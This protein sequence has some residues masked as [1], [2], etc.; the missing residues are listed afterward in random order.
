MIVNI[1]RIVL[2]ILCTYGI[3]FA[4]HK[5]WEITRELTWWNFPS[6]VFLVIAI[7]IVW[8]WGM[9]KWKTEDK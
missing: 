5:I 1:L 4:I 2:S 6:F 9:E 8:G 7:I 3:C